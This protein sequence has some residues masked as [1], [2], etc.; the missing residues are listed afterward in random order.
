MHKNCM[1]MFTVPLLVITKSWNKHKCLFN[2]KWIEK[3]GITES[4]PTIKAKELRNKKRDIHMDPMNTKRKTKEDYGQLYPHKSDNLDEME[5]LLKRHN[6]LKLT[7]EKIDNLDRPI[8]ITEIKSII[9]NF[10]R[11]KHQAQV[12]SLVNSAKHLRKKL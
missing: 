10:H 12:G 6:L 3:L 7:Q 5:Q 4:Y 8:S 2:G 11:R 9:N 1:R